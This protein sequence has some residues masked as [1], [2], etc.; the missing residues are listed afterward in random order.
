MRDGRSKYCNCL[1]FS[2]G[3]L[4]RTLSRI[5]EEEFAVTGLAPSYAFLLMGVN[6]TPGIG[7]GALAEEMQL[8]ASTVTRLVDKMEAKGYVKRKTSGK[9]AKIYPTQKSKDLDES[10]R[11]AWDSLYKRYTNVLGET[12]AKKLTT[13]V[14]DAERSLAG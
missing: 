8:A 5:A 4:S 12:T 2:S 1:F 7:P 3:A 14:Y 13:A 6:E 9:A 11:N 10:I